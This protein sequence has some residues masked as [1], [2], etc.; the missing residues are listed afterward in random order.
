MGGA[1][2]LPTLESAAHRGREAFWAGRARADCPYEPLSAE[3]ASW[4]EAFDAA[5]QVRVF[6]DQHLGREG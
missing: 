3:C 1:P 2:L 6:L 4:L 5:R